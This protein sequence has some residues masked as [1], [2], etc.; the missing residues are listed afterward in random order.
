M[1]NTQAALSNLG[2]LNKQFAEAG[3]PFNNFASANVQLAAQEQRAR[4]L[5]MDQM[6]RLQFEAQAAMERQQAQIQ[7]HEGLTKWQG[8]QRH[9]DA[10]EIAKLEIAARRDQ[11]IAKQADEIRR[12]PDAK[13]V[14]GQL[15][16]STPNTPEGNRKL[17]EEHAARFSDPKVKEKL[18]TD[19]A[20]ILTKQIK[21]ALANITDL[22]DNTPAAK[23]AAQKFLANPVVIDL[24]I[25]KGKLSP[26]AV[27]GLAQDP[28]KIGEKIKEASKNAA[29]LWGQDRNV[30]AQLVGAW[31]GA[32][33]E[34]GA[35]ANPAALVNVDFLQSMMKNR[36][37]LFPQIRSEDSWKRIS[38][39]Q[40]FGAK[41]INRIPPS[42]TGIEQPR[43]NI[44]NPNITERNPFTPVQQSM[45]ETLGSGLAQ[46]LTPNL[47]NI[48]PIGGDQRTLAFHTQPLAQDPFTD[49]QIRKELLTDLRNR[50]AAS[51]G[52]IMGIYQ[53]QSKY[54]PHDQIRDEI[55]LEG[56]VQQLYMPQSASQ[57]FAPQEPAQVQG[58]ISPQN[59]F[60]PRF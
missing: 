15:I 25:K 11:E 41:P 38:E 3:A 54:T 52:G 33:A 4:Q 5:Q 32:L 10:L 8:Q 46:K 18:S 34:S 31:Q 39:A 23:Q 28:A 29:L 60:A 1:D 36:D 50:S 21:N 26:E 40:G 2:L 49:L 17:V 59:P 16:A 42:T 12:D 9:G 6:A 47:G 53:P 44:V 19:R 37:A 24:L 22:T 35:V 57:Q 14:M 20:V 56:L 7:A 30:A 45:P 51:S 27:Q 58:L 13:E 43:A 48:G 55:A